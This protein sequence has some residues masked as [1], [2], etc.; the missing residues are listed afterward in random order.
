MAPEEEDRRAKFMT[1]RDRALAIIVLSVEPSLLYLLGNPEDPVAV[2]KKLAD[3][4]QKKTWANKLEL[5]RKLYSLRLKDGDSVHAHIK[6]MTEVF[7]A[8]AVIDDPVSEE[9]QVVHLLASLPETYDMLVTALEANAEVPK[10]ELVTERL[11]HEERKLK[12]RV[13]DS[14]G[15]VEFRSVTIVETTVTSRETVGILHS[16]R[17]KVILDRLVG[18]S[19]KLAQLMLR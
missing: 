18:P 5:R 13:T 6:S 3:Q 10:M 1:K 15:E 9:D 8:L 14:E 17:V 11:L 4:F 12:G 19:R 7:E 2:W 16:R